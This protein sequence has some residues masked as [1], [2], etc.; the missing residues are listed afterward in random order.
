MTSKVK[1]KAE[2]QGTYRIIIEVGQHARAVLDF[3]EKDMATLEFNRIRT[4]GTYCGRW[5]NRI[6]MHEP[7]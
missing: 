7:K 4:A 1:A 3:T 6:E 2:P 5:V